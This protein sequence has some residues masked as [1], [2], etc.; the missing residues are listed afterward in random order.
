[1]NNKQSSYDTPPIKI[2][3][4]ARFDR[5]ITGKRKALGQSVIDSAIKGGMLCSLFHFIG[6]I[7]GL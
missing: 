5:R 1:M 7:F 4:L 6:V 3:D 2:L